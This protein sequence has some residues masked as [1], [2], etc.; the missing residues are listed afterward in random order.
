MVGQSEAHAACSNK[1][2]QCST[3]LLES[4]SSWNQQSSDRKLL[5]Q[6]QVLS[7]H[8]LLTARKSTYQSVGDGGLH[9]GAGVQDPH[10]VDGGGEPS[11]VGQP[12]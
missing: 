10:G 1:M 12:V 11:L 9:L 3:L 4:P 8:L 7:S 6:N 5:H 2:D